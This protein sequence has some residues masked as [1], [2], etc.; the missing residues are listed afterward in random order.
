MR[1]SQGWEDNRRL[2][3]VAAK[4]RLLERLIVTTGVGIGRVREQKDAYRFDDNGEKIPSPY[5]VVE[6]DSRGQTFRV[7]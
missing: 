3:Q 2:A 5:V 4:I 6:I 7:R 1:C